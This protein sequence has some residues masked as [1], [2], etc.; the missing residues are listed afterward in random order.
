MTPLP[1][2]MTKIEVTPP[3]D[4]EWCPG[5]H[6]FLRFPK[7]G[8]LDNHPF[9]M[10]SAPRSASLTL[11]DKDGKLIFLARTHTGFTRHL[12]K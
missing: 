4:F 12:A 1:G 5:Q 11:D 10:T 3:V 9:T 7:L 6:V 2:G 8:M